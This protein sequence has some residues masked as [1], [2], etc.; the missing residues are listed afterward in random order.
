MEVSAKGAETG[1]TFSTEKKI[2]QSISVP[3]ARKI[4]FASTDSF[5]GA[6]SRQTFPELSQA[7]L[8]GE[9][10]VPQLLTLLMRFKLIIN[11]NIDQK[12]ETSKPTYLFIPRWTAS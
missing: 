4:V 2:S 6:A 7:S 1:E 9:Q 8:I 12:R 5:D 10:K 3:W 11:E